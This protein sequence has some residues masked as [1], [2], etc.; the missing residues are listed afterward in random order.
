VEKTKALD[1][2]KKAANRSE[3]VCDLVWAVINTREFLLQH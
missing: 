3:A 1:H 2:F